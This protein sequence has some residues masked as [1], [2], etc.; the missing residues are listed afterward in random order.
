MRARKGPGGTCLQKWLLTIEERHLIFLERMI[1]TQ[2]QQ[3]TMVAQAV[4]AWRRTTEC[5]TPSWP[6]QSPLCHPAP[7]PGPVLSLAAGCHSGPNSS[8]TWTS[9]SHPP[10]SPESW[11]CLTSGSHLAGT[12]PKAPCLKHL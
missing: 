6:G 1:K 8:H 9:G 5:W 7:D 11:P 2:E 10:L 12:S 4:E 3:F